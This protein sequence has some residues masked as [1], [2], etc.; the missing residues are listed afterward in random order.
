MADSERSYI[1]KVCGTTNPSIYSFCTKC[2][3]KRIS[4]REKTSA[5]TNKKIKRDMFYVATISD[6]DLCM[7]IEKN[8]LFFRVIFYMIGVLHVLSGIAIIPTVHG[9]AELIRYQSDIGLLLYI[10]PGIIILFSM[11]WFAIGNLIYYKQVGLSCLI[12]QGSKRQGQK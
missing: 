2:G 4:L 1:C 6:M 7:A 5:S 8:A 9:F 11:I 3:A 10:I 12:Q